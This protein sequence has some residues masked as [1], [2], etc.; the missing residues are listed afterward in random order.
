MKDP[1]KEKILVAVAWPYVNGDIHVGHLAGYLLPADIYARFHRLRGRDVLMVSGS[2]CYGTPI[3]VE[4]EKRGVDPQEIVNEYHPKHKKLFSDLKLTFD[5]FTKTTTENHKKVVQNIFLS[6][7]EKGYVFKK[8]TNQY[9]SEQEG[10]FLPDRYVEGT[11]PHCGFEEARSDQCDDCGSLVEEGKL[12]KPRSTN[13]GS[14]VTLRETEHYFLDWSKLSGFFEDY[15]DDKGDSWR[16]W[17]INETKGWLKKGLQPRA[18]TRDLE[19]GI[20][21]PNDEIPEDQRLENSER[22]RFYVWFEAVIGYLSASIE[23]ADKNEWKEFWYGDNATHAYFLGKDN[24]LFHTLFWPGELH[25]YDEDLHLPDIPAV[26]QFLNFEDKQ[27]SKSRGVV[28]DSRYIVEEYG[29]DPVRFYLTA[30]MPE[31][32]D[33]S[34]SWADFVEKHNNILIGNL[35]NFINRSLKMAK[36]FNDFDSNDLDIEIVDEVSSFLDSARNNLSKCEFR[37]YL[38]NTLKLSDKANKYLSREEPWKVDDNL[39]KKKIITNALFVVLA[40][41]LGIE[42]VLV[43]ASTKLSELLGVEMSSWS[44]DEIYLLK[45]KLEEV[46]VKATEPLFEKIDEEIIEKEQSKE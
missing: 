7:V 22:K 4:A 33:S 45:R 40:L 17:V 12:K 24:L 23:W 14:K 39:E 16:K 35:G 1:K 34:F 11:C 20:E 2:D 36:E 37:A 25:L 38:D 21:I 42:P 43:E 18:I 32:S 13:T 27:F 19:W 44:D 46:D 15:V 9:Y 10:R 28:I 6:A 3:T 26:N 30:I 41:R 29:L 31:A 5:N 8:N